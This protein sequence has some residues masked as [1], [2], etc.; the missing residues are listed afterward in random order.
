MHKHSYHSTQLTHCIPLSIYNRSSWITLILSETSHKLLANLMI[1]SN[2]IF[3]FVVH[4]DSLLALMITSS[5]KI[6]Y[7][8]SKHGN[9]AAILV[10]SLQDWAEYVALPTEY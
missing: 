9:A 2:L 6:I 1:L 8:M 10:M 5:R 4:F 7:L 3:S